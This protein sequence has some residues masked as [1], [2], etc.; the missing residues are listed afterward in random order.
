MNSSRITGLIPLFL[1]PEEGYHEL[2]KEIDPEGFNED[3]KEQLGTFLSFLKRSDL[4]VLQ[5]LYIESF[6]MNP[7]TT[8]DLGWHLYGENY[9]RGKFL[10][11]VRNLMRE[12]GIKESTELP[13]HLTHIIMVISRMESA[14]QNEFGKNYIIPAL[15]KIA[16]GF[17][18]TDNPYKHLIKFINKFFQNQ[19]LEVIP[20]G[21]IQ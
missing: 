10:V 13:D 7:S 18:N 3:E 11:K 1:Y 16:K 9:N 19:F 5:E 2:L 4:K 12:K 14:E 8:L 21:S 20:D 6:D 15:K 17:E